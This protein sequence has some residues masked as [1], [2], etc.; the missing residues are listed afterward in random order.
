M[1]NLF[2]FLALFAVVTLFSQHEGTITGNIVDLEMSGEPLMLANISLKGTKWNTQTNFNGNF[3][4]KHV[5]P[6]NYILEICSLG[7]E[8]LKMPIEV[9]KNGLIQIER[10]MKAK[11]ISLENVSY[12]DMAETNLIKTSVNTEKKLP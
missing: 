12:S 10:G 1:K 2:L 3:E 4:I 11:S 5:A 7:Y 8:S 6:G 9:L